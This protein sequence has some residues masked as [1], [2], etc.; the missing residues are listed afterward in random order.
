MISNRV[1]IDMVRI[2]RMEDII[3]KEKDSFIDRVLTPGEREYVFSASSRQRQAEHLAG[4]FAAKE[5]ASKALGTGVM[6][7]GV[8]F[9]DFEII[10]SVSGAPELCLRGRAKEV[11]DLMGVIGGMF[12]S[13]HLLGEGEYAAAFCSFLTDEKD[14]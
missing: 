1:G 4:R 3:S 6:S 13:I 8:A 9:T 14:K 5:A 11:A 12:F 2:S 7:D 10:P